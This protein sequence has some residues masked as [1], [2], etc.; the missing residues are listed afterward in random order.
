MIEGY[1]AGYCMVCG[2]LQ[3]DI[4]DHVIIAKGDG[5][6]SMREGGMI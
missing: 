2:A 5:V 4:H 6:F 3:I 1:G